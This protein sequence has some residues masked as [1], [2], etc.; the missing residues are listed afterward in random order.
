[1]KF[2]VDA[3]EFYELINPVLSV[4]PGRT[5]L[6]VLMNFI[7]DVKKEGITVYATDL[8]VSVLV[9]GHGKIEE[10]GKIGIPAKS[11][12]EIMKNIDG[13]VEFELHE[14]YLLCRYPR[15]KVNFPIIMPEDYPEAIVPKEE[16]G[17]EIDRRTLADMVEKTSFAAAISERAARRAMVGVLFHI[18]DDTLKLVASDGT[19]LAFTSKNIEGGEPIKVIVPSQVFGFIKKMKD[20][21]IKI[22][23][24]EGR[25]GISCE[26]MV[27]SARLIEEEYPDYENVIPWD[28]DKIFSIEKDRFIE[29][30][31]RISIF[32]SPQ[33]KGIEFSLSPERMVVRARSEMGEAE[34]EIE[35]EF[36]GSGID[37]IFNFQML[38]EII[39]RIDDE[40]I[41][42]TF[43]EPMSPTLIRGKG[44]ED[45]FYLLMPL[46][47]S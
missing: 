8:E 26:N 15:G 27:V 16:G 39:R 19:R 41:E 5:T 6:P 13:E 4:V 45:Q 11:F 34:E 2:N 10:E 44:R 36:Y 37:V 31:K 42:I 38:I 25:I 33:S 35:G 22:K 43:K 9:K 1:M 14:S 17:F 40:K 28:N 23:I 21:R 20:D 30:V 46:I 12:G 24:E 29:V 3:Q 18:E 7:L 32:A 47:G